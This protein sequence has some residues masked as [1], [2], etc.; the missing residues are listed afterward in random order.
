MRPFIRNGYF[1]TVSPIENSSIRIGDVVFYSTAENNVIV[2]R[3]INKYGK[4]GNMKL[5]IKGDAGFGPTERVSSQDVLG[6]VVVI[7]RNGRE[8]RLD[9]KL[10]RIICLFFAGLSPFSRWIYPIGSRVKH[11]GRR[12]VSPN[13]HS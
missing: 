3:I 4:N 12:W 8:R 11:K 7:E 10:Y 1:I 5:L 9:T 6:K 13:F 2:H